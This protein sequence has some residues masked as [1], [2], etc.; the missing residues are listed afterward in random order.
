MGLK[1]KHSG[2]NSVS[3][4]PPT[5]NPSGDISFKLPQADGSNGQYMKTD[6][7]GALSFGTVATYTQPDEATLKAWADFDGDGDVNATLTGGNIT[8]LTDHST[9]QY[10][11]T[12]DT[13]FSDDNYMMCGSHSHQ[14]FV[15]FQ[16]ESDVTA[17]SCRFATMNDGGGYYDSFKTTV[18]FWR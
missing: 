7:S 3:L 5:N 2:G 6:G 18:G 12:F 17:G 14:G 4:V 13:D 1:L 9:G 11:I 16:S 15:G 10:T 8:S